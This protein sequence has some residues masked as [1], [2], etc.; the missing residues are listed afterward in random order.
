MPAQ[1]LFKFDARQIHKRTAPELWTTPWLARLTTFGGG[2]LLTLYGGYEMYKVIDVGGVTTLKWA[3]LGLFLLNFSWIALS[4]MSAVV[5]FILLL[6]KPP[7]P[8]MPNKLREKLQSLCL[9]IMKRQAACLLHFK[10][11]MKMFKRQD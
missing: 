9:F 11:F 10:Q 8:S 5:G 1:H 6:N 7:T 4:F 3:L 2:F